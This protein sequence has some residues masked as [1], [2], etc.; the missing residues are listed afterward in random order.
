LYSIND[1]KCRILDN[2]Q[3][4]Q[5]LDSISPTYIVRRTFDKPC[6]QVV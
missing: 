3:K 1:L 2:E 5:N 4:K 6:I